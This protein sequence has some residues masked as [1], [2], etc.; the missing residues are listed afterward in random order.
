MK[1]VADLHTKNPAPSHPEFIHSFLHV[2][3]PQSAL[4]GDGW[5]PQREIL[6]PPPE[7]FTGKVK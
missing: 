4:V 6:D 3:L 7:R 1:A 5:R 2:F